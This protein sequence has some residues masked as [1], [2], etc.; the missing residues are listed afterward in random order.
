MGLSQGHLITDDKTEDTRLFRTSLVI[1]APRG[2]VQVST[3][4]EIC[5]KYPFIHDTKNAIEEVE[6]GIVGN[7]IL[8][9]KGA[10][11]QLLA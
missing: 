7:S 6:S 5:W 10:D 9:E 2:A 1:L 3:T 11:F 8:R 4:S